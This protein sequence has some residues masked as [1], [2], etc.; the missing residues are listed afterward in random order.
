MRAVLDITKALGDETR[1]RVLLALRH[2]ELCLCHLVGL[3]QLAPSTVSKHLDLLVRAGLVQ[4]RKHGRWAYFRLAG[5]D[6]P[7]AARQALRWILAALADD[8]AIARDA[9]RL[10]A[11]RRCD[12]KELAACYKS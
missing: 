10:N 2:G 1:V 6:A 3:L 11:L 12:P 7:A 4:R 9:Q 5:R 8:P